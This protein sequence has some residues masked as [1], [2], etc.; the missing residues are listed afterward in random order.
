M[1]S[2]VPITELFMGTAARDKLDRQK[3]WR[4]HVLKEAYVRAF[5]Q[6]F[7]GGKWVTSS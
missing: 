4:D 3:R 1:V 2:S 7:V 6:A 5:K